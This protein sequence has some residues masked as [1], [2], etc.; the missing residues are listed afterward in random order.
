M[1]ANNGRLPIINNISCKYIC[2]MSNIDSQLQC[3]K[4]IMKKGF[5]HT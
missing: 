3:T 2:I 5:S 1:V 4:R